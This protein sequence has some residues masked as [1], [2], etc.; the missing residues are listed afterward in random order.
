M[1]SARLHAHGIKQTKDALTFVSSDI[2]RKVPAAY[3]RHLDLTSEYQAKGISHNLY[4]NR[5]TNLSMNTL[6]LKGATTN[7][8]HITVKK[9]KE[10]CVRLDSWQRTWS[11]I[12]VGM[13]RVVTALGE[14][15]I[16]DILPSHGQHDSKR[17]TCIKS[18]IPNVKILLSM[19]DT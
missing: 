8:V 5:L 9:T 17:Y 12:A 4:Q 3:I 11:N 18:P 13:A 6:H 10:N 15:T 2:T 1:T 7:T 19:H 16:P 14:S